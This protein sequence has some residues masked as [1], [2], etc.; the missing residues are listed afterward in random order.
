MQR[1]LGLLM[2]AG[3]VLYLPDFCFEQ[4]FLFSQTLRYTQKI[5][6]QVSE[7]R[8]SVI[9]NIFFRFIFIVCLDSGIKS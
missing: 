8:D 4:N 2:R 3:R 7:E 5:N 9:L 1:G 6:P